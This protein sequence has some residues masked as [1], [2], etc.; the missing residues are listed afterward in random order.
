MIANPIVVLLE[1]QNR[2]LRRQLDLA[3]TAAVLLLTERR[4]EV[5]CRDIAKALAVELGIPLGAES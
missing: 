1:A 2:E 4:A 3:K 5:N